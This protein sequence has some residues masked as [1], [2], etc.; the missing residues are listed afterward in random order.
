MGEI[1][2]H[3]GEFSNLDLSPYSLL[4]YYK[5]EAKDGLFGEMIN[6]FT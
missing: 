4:A 3:P 1:M 2:V 6:V 5:N